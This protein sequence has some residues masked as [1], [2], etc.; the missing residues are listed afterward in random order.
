MFLG[1]VVC[2]R[3]GSTQRP[4]HCGLKKA[5]VL[6]Q[7]YVFHGLDW[8]LYHLGEEDSAWMRRGLEM[9]R[10]RGRRLDRLIQRDCE[11][12]DAGTDA[13]CFHPLLHCCVPSRERRTRPEAPCQKCPSPTIQPPIFSNN[14]S[15]PSANAST[16]RALAAAAAAPLRPSCLFF[17]CFPFFFFWPDY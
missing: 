10:R 3:G 4:A 16:L 5:I 6:G 11:S 14:S 8:E 2:I 15:S 12:W 9:A 7:C 13:D 17:S 1:A